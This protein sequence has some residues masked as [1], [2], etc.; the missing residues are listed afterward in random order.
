MSDETD[1]WKEPFAERDIDL[2]E[3][4]A[5]DDAGGDWFQTIATFTRRGFLRVAASPHDDAL[6]L[7]VQLALPGARDEDA[8]KL[9]DHFKNLSEA[10]WS[11]EGEQRPWV[12]EARV[13]LGDPLEVT[14]DAFEGLA[15]GVKRVEAG[16]EVDDVLAELFGEQTS[17]DAPSSE[18]ETG[19]EA[20]HS[21]KATPSDDRSGSKD[22][23]PFEQIGDAADTDTGGESTARA[24]DASLVSFQCGVSDDLVEINLEIDG[25]LDERSEKKLREALERALRA[26]FDAVT[27]NFEVEHG[28][29]GVTVTLGVEPADLGAAGDETLGALSDDIKSF[30]ER[31]ER[32]NKLGMSLFEVLAPQRRTR[33]RS[34]DESSSRTA[35]VS[36]DEESSRSSTRPKDERKRRDGH[37]RPRQDQ[38]R[39]EPDTSGV[40]LSFGGAELDADRDETTLEPGDYTDERLRRPD[41][42]TPLV[43]VVLRHPGYS[44]KSMRQVLSILLDIDYFEADRLADDAPCIIAWGVSQERAQEFKR[45]IENAGGRVTLVEPDSL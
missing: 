12:L 35:K 26:R 10:D 44:D 37:M 30:F 28:D 21:S 38:R 11:L 18:E 34:E 23:G 4:S 20:E 6:E 5:P 40:V 2:S 16:E 1:T 22:S 13:P 3:V 39:A 17:E 7:H 8:E 31:I 32:F 27:A 15:E 9:K 43:D 19:D 36:S 24:G 41:A 33:T 14:I 25:D 29:G 42:T 45:V